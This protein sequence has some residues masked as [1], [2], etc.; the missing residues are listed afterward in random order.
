MK[1]VGRYQFVQEFQAIETYT[2]AM[3]SRILGWNEMEIQVM[4]AKVKKELADRSIHLY[5]P[6]YVVYGRK[7]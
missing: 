3:F 5:L 6:I 1:T 4:I 2:P 7:P